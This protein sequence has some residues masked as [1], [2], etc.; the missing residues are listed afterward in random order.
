M[1]RYSRSKIFLISFGG[2]EDCGCRLMLL[3]LPSDASLAVAVGAT[4]EE[5]M[6]IMADDGDTV[7]AENVG[8]EDI[9]DASGVTPIPMKR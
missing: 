9:N 4:P 5:L 7:V 6:V 1:S 8:R 2:K 3:L